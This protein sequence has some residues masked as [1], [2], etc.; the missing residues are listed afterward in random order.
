VFSQNERSD[1]SAK[2]MFKNKYETM[3][4]SPTVYFI[5]DSEINLKHLQKNKI[6]RIE[7][8]NEDY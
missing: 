8:E 3:F 5:N 7:K 4:N 2:L 1:K 6:F